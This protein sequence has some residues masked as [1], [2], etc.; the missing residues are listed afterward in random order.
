M[1]SSNVCMLSIH[2]HVKCHSDVTRASWRLKSRDTQLSA[3][4]LSNL[5][6]TKITFLHCCEENSLE[7]GGFSSKRAGNAVVVSMSWRHHI[8]CIPCTI[9]DSCMYINTL[10]FMICLHHCRDTSR[11]YQNKKNPL[12]LAWF[13]K[14]VDYRQLIIGNVKYIAQNISTCSLTTALLHEHH[15]HDLTSV[16]KRLCLFN[17]LFK[18]QPNIKLRINGPLWG[19]SIG[20]WFPTIMDQQ[21]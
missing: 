8:S 9:V 19:E 11:V 12:R 2:I 17:S 16:S 21:F 14:F 10:V 3:Q 15:S 13:I 7:S 4:N 1:I 18:V 20:Y 6:R 5:I